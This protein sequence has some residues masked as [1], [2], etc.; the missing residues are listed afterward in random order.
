[1]T[2]TFSSTSNDNPPMINVSDEESKQTIKRLLKKLLKLLGS[3]NTSTQNTLEKHERETVALAFCIATQLL[4]F[5]TFET[6]AE[7]NEQDARNVQIFLPRI[8]EVRNLITADRFDFRPNG[9]KSD[10]KKSN[11]RNI[12]PRLDLET[13]SA[14]NKTTK[15]MEYDS[16]SKTKPVVD[17]VQAVDT[18]SDT[19]KMK[20]QEISPRA[21]LEANPFILRKTT[22]EYDSCSSSKPVVNVVQTVEKRSD[23]NKISAPK[24]SL[25]L[26]LETNHSMPR[27]RI[28]RYEQT[29]SSKPVLK[30]IQPK[31]NIGK[32]AKQK[33]YAN[34][35]ASSRY[36]AEENNSQSIRDLKNNWSV[37]SRSESPQ[38]APNLTE[39]HSSNRKL[40]RRLSLNQTSLPNV[41]SSHQ[42]LFAVS[43]INKLDHPRFEYALSSDSRK[44]HPRFLQQLPNGLSRSPLSPELDKQAVRRNFR[45]L[46][47][48][49]DARKLADYMFQGDAFSYDER[50]M[51]SQASTRALANEL[52]FNFLMDNETEKAFEEFKKALEKEYPHV[53]KVLA[54]DI[55]KCVS[56]KDLKRR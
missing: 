36:F 56:S 21:D 43:Q 1:M 55:L 24:K 30:S 35:S 29:P 46:K 31:D 20:A 47:T 50:T 28:I 19:K 10:T 38:S 33:H 39:D 27:K 23:T 12:S 25:R 17:F 8:H 22:L 34:N 42:L 53:A 49:I 13:N 40:S 41:R 9:P 5:Y 26:D 48:E 15:I 2:S 4:H 51:V 3:I 18:N 44:M 32:E 11:A 14:T 54:D 7:I 6:D 52:F 37:L 16:S 45:Y